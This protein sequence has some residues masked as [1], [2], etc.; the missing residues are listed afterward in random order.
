MSQSCEKCRP[1]YHLQLYT[2]PRCIHWPKIIDV[3]HVVSQIWT[4]MQT[5]TWV[6][7][8]E[9]VG[10]TDQT[11][12]WS[13]ITL[14][15]ASTDQKSLI[16]SMAKWAI[17]IISCLFVYL[18]TSIKYNFCTISINLHFMNLFKMSLIVEDDIIEKWYHCH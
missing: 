10:Q 4:L 17:V 8:A 15:D 7:H 9:N 11:I 13:C 16:W 2:S 18:S 1:N 14:Q 12:S 5:L 3:W 6:S